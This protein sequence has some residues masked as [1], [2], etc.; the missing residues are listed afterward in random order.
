MITIIRDERPFNYSALNNVA[1]EQAGG[2]LLCCSTTT[3]RSMGGDWLEEMV[4]Q[5]LQAGVGIVG[6]KL[7]YPDGTIQHAGVTLG[8][9]G[10]AG[11]LHR[12]A[13]RFDLGYF[14]DLA[15]T[16][17][18]SAVTGACMLIRRDVWDDLGGLD[19]TDLAV[20]FNDIDFCLRAQES[21]WAVIWTPFAELIHHE[22]ISRGPDDV[23]PRVDE[24]AARSNT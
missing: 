22:S 5:I 18:V 3:S 1:A 9:D 13:D 14:G 23:G 10:V 16:R 15:L 12:G 20:A 17:R 7:D 24:F 19:A 2:E 4:S 8:I 11:H 6:A 21:G